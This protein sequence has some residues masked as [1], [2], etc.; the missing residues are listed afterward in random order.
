MDHSNDKYLP[1]VTLSV[2]VESTSLLQVCVIQIYR[3]TLLIKPFTGRYVLYVSYACRMS[4][5]YPSLMTTYLI[6]SLQ[7]G[8]TELSL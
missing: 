1:F 2:S 8:R 4:F 7:H 3:G 6:Y 5:R